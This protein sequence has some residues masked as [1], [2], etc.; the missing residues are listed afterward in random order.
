R[1]LGRLGVGSNALVE[2]P[3]LLTEIPEPGVVTLLAKF[4]AHDDPDG[5]AAAIEA[6]VEVGD[7]SAVGALEKLRD[8]KRKTRL[9]DEEELEGGDV[10]VGELAEEAIQLLQA[11]E[12]HGE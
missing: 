10:T 2:L 4:L 1:A 7:P 3:Y 8:D 5:V 9:G 11:M 6:L 12:E